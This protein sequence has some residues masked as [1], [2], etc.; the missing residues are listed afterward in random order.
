MNVTPRQ[1]SGKK[2][3]IF[4]NQMSTPTNGNND[5]ST[6]HTLSVSIP[7][8]ISNSLRDQILKAGTNKSGFS[9]K[10]GYSDNNSNQNDDILLNINTELYLDD[11]HHQNDGTNTFTSFYDGSGYLSQPSLDIS[12]PTIITVI[13][14]SQSDS[15][16]EKR[17]RRKDRKLIIS[18][19]IHQGS[20]SSVEVFGYDDNKK[21]TKSNRKRN[22]KNS[23]FNNNENSF[24]NRDIDIMNYSS[25]D[26]SEAFKEVQKMNY[27]KFSTTGAQTTVSV[28]A[29]SN[30]KDNFQNT[31]KLNQNKPINPND[32]FSSSHTQTSMSCVVPDSTNRTLR[33]INAFEIQE[34][35]STSIDSEMN[36]TPNRRIKNIKN[37]SSEFS[38]SSTDTENVH[39]NR[40]PFTSHNKSSS[41]IHQNSRIIQD[42]DSSIKSND[43]SPTSSAST[44]NFSS[45]SNSS[46]YQN[47]TRT[48]QKNQDHNKKNLKIVESSNFSST[49]SSVISLQKISSSSSHKS[50]RMYKKK[51]ENMTK[52]I[53]DEDENSYNSDDSSKSSSYYSNT[54][55]QSSSSKEN[56]ANENSNSSSYFSYYSST[57]LVEPK[58]VIKE[59]FTN[60]KKKENSK[61]EKESRKT[62][63]KRRSASARKEMS[64]NTIDEPIRQYKLRTITP[65]PEKVTPTVEPHQKRSASVTRNTSNEKRNTSPE[66]K[67]HNHSNK[68]NDKETYR[69]KYKTPTLNRK[70]DFLDSK[71][72][73]N[74]DFKT[75]NN[76]NNNNNNEEKIQSTPRSE[77]RAKT[78][79]FV[80]DTVNTHITD[81]PIKYESRKRKP[82]VETVLSSSTTM[83]IYSS[84]SDEIPKNKGK[85]SK[86]SS[87]ISFDRQPFGPS[88][89]QSLLEKIQ[90]KL[91]E[92]ESSSSIE[93]DT[94][95]YL[96]S[97]DFEQ[98][99]SPVKGRKNKRNKNRKSRNTPDRTN[100]DHFNKIE[101]QKVRRVGNE[102]SD[103]SEFEKYFYAPSSSGGN[104]DRQ[105]R[106]IAPKKKVCFDT[107]DSIIDSSTDIGSASDF[108][109]DFKNLN[110]KTQNTYSDSK[111]SK[112]PKISPTQANS[113]LKLRK[114]QKA[115]S[116]QNSTKDLKNNDDSDYTYS[117]DTTDSPENSYISDNDYEINK[118]KITINNTNENVCKNS[119]IKPDNKK[120]I[121]IITPSQTEDNPN[122]KNSSLKNRNITSE[123]IQNSLN[124]NSSSEFELEFKLAKKKMLKEKNNRKDI[125]FRGINLESSEIVDDARDVPVVIKKDKDISDYSSDFEKAYAKV[126]KNQFSFDDELKDSKFVSKKKKTEESDVGETQIFQIDQSMLL[127]QNES[128]SPTPFFKKRISKNNTPRIQNISSPKEPQKPKSDKKVLSNNK[129]SSSNSQKKPS[130]TASP[131]KNVKPNNISKTLNKPNT[132][133]NNFI[134]NNSQSIKKEMSQNIPPNTETTNVQTDS[135]M[136]SR[137]LLDAINMN[138]LSSEFQLTISESDFKPEN[139]EEV[140]ESVR[141][142][143]NPKKKES[144]ES[145]PNKKPEKEGV[146]QITE[147]LLSSS[148]SF[149]PTDKEYD[150][151]HRIDNNSGENKENI[152]L[153]DKNNSSQNSVFS[154]KNTFNEEE[155]TSGIDFGNIDY[156]SSSSSRKRN[157]KKRM[158]S[159]E[160]ASSSSAKDIEES[161]TL[162]NPSSKRRSSS[163]SSSKRKMKYSGESVSDSSRSSRRRKHS[164]SSSKPKK[165]KN[166]E[167]D[168]I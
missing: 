104:H 35:E 158:I 114:S 79:E 149:V 139:E 145:P 127:Q 59:N 136:T 21:S 49:G 154:S 15:K 120:E 103:A 57:D 133:N 115:K 164:D 148:S 26:V 159:N 126:R 5:F 86:P 40:E 75:P 147:D 123:L 111:F 142:V 110:R 37:N 31:P 155:S 161:D 3:M 92:D 83:D 116:S 117:S 23:K 29:V 87:F 67:K 34:N 17:N 112:S 12:T 9:N 58:N 144:K 68:E 61:T 157:S 18:N 141:D 128:S 69:E 113:Q 39:K 43:Y 32:K 98:S 77:R 153:A 129:I 46:S 91:S 88:S 146:Y 52:E 51:I 71:I 78:P 124:M 97:D 62:N 118:R 65:I 41:Y 106:F 27:S 60:K 7:I 122:V 10:G 44:S 42:S 162:V 13:N 143:I 19:P 152:N 137:Q 73:V 163:Q 100:K 89:R 28:T 107:D 132:L 76:N 138:S 121:K 8:Q 55:E 84:D 108:G 125:S 90:S 6:P 99:P 47:K 45:A 20:L 70:N 166:N 135:K 33:T 85:V 11:F 165:K 81:F 130:L 30:K 109:K 25:S 101:H 80:S 56:L 119:M 151:L 72:R 167:K 94:P 131:S 96:S 168:S 150:A 63:I 93:N 50:A 4:D 38:F 82:V 66:T 64:I 2:A 95:K 156:Y 24:D 54:T 102:Q 36:I 140:K 48:K 105:S 134:V 22:K 16:R 74:F 1:F 53:S 160:P 14:T